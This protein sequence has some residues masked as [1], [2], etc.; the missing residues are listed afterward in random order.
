MKTEKLVIAN[1]IGTSEFSRGILWQTDGAFSHS[2]VWLTDA[3]KKYIRGLVG[4]DQY[5]ELNIEAMQLIEQ[6][7][8]GG[9]FFKAWFDFNDLSDHEP[10][11][12]YELWSLDMPLT[13]WEY[14]MAHYV[15]SL[16]ER[17]DWAAILHF[18]IKTIKER[19]DRSICSEKCIEPVA[20][21]REWTHVKPFNV[22]PTGLVALFQ[23]AG[24]QLESKHV[25]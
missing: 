4:E 14:C 11:T 24:G 5:R 13:D 18:R 15:K 10:G 1:F 19:P 25:V 20:R 2:A 22:H 23:A 21:I 7:P 9:D 12:P 16:G 17:Y 8:H 3:A 6:W